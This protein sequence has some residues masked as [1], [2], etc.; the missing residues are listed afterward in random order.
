MKITFCSASTHNCIIKL[1][2]PQL[3]NKYAVFLVHESE[4][5]NINYERNLNDPRIAHSL[6]IEVDDFGNVLQSASVAYGR[7]ITDAHLPVA[8][9][10][11]QSKVHV[12]YTT[13]SYTNL[14]DTPVTYR[15]K[16]IAETKTY[17][18]TNNAYNPISSFSINNLL[19][20]FAAATSIAYEV[21]A[22]GSLQKRLIEDVQTIYLSN[23]LKTPLP[24][25]Q[26]DTLGFIKQTYKLA[27]SPSLITNLYAAR[28]T[29][30][31]L[32]DAK[33]V[34]ADGIN[35]GFFRK[36]YLFK[37]DRNYC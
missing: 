4:A 32:T 35:C 27:F 13:N 2:Q 15:L 28:V 16:A 31:M 7:K 19:N 6:N 12:V 37:R 36:K 18:V 25:G 23:D 20:D 11:E 1:L 22:N 3:N 30:Q 33:Y 29:N 8:I 5:L 24:P 9:Q 17:E 14:F 34:Q 10:D 21:S 26:L